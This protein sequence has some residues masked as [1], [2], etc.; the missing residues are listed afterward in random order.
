MVNG[1]NLNDLG[2]SNQITFQPT[3][4]TIDEFKVDNSTFNAEYGFKSGAIVN[5]AARSGT[6]QWHGEL[7]EYV[8]NHDLDARNFGNPSGITQAA[9]HRNQF[10]A[11]G[12]GPVKRDKTFFYLSYEGL[13]HLQGVPLQAT[14]LSPT[15]RAQAQATGDSVIQ[16]L[17]PLIPLANSP[18]NVFVTT[19]P[20]P[21]VAN[22]G[23]ANFSQVLSSANRLNIYYAYQADQR[24]EPPSTVNNDL[25]GYGDLRIG[26]RQ[27][28]TINDT[29]VISASWVNEFRLG[30]NRLHIPFLP[31]TTLTAAQFGIN[32]GVTPMP[33]I[34]IAGGTLEFGGNNG[35]PQFR[36]DY[37]TV[38]S[39][40]VSWVH[41]KHTI[42]FGGEFRWHDNNNY[43]YTPGTITFPS[44]AAFIADQATG[45]T[46]NPSNRSSRIFVEQLG[47]FLQDS[48]KIMPNFV[49]EL[50]LRY[51]WNGT[52]V[53][54]EERFVVFEPTLDSLAEVGTNSGPGLAYNQNV[55]VTLPGNT[56]FYIVLLEPSSGA[57]QADAPAKGSGNRTNIAAAGAQSLPTA[58]E[59]RELIS[60]RDELNRLYRE[61]AATRTA[62]PQVPLQ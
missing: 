59:L 38:A 31:Q 49:L 18:G 29:E 40:T 46:A 16:Q 20:A 5:M 25:P 41:G 28:L 51:D 2:G 19:A 55:V 43:S 37:T 13:R 62:D 1:I 33:Q 57:L 7:Y 50:G 52:P 4:G 45:F 58:G 39:D 12:G 24:N 34:I 17:L 6:N 3:I 54:A 14:V 26:N 47:A 61:V 32:S 35:E 56:R 11:N 48:Y 27:L 23:T 60:L 10:G 30:Y 8:R 44:I 21:V 36:G 53:E 42:K 15:Q 9:F 22:Q